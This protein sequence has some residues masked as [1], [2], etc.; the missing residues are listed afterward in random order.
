MA[1]GTPPTAL[2]KAITRSR[3]AMTVTHPSPQGVIR[4]CTGH[5]QH[6]CEA[7]TATPIDGLP[8]RPHLHRHSTSEL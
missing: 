7:A 8:S 6:I 2:V 5:Q 1:Y 4:L 3:T